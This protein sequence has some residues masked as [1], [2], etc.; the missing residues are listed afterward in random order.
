MMDF[1][2][3][4]S[5]S[6]MTR[7]EGLSRGSEEIFMGSAGREVARAV[8]EYVEGHGLAKQ[9]TLLA[10]K[11]N[12]GGDAYAAGIFLLDAGFHVHAYSLYDEGSSLNCLYRE[13]F[14]KK[15]GQFVE[16]LEGVLVDG[17]LGT[18]FRGEIE[19]KLASFIAEIN[20]SGLPVISID[21]PSG[22]NGTTGEVLGIAVIADETVTLG[23]PKMGLFL[24]DGWNHVGNLRVAD[25]GLPQE[26]I[27]A[28]E[29]L[30]YLPKHLDLPRIVRNRHKYQAG[31]VVGMGGSK[32]MPG[33]VKLAGLAALKA[34][35]GIVRLFHLEEIGPV[36]NELISVDWDAKEWKRGVEKAQAIFVGPG[37]GKSR[38]MRAWLKKY[39][40]TIKQHCVIDAD[41]LLPG[42]S[43][44]KKAVLTPHKGEVLRLLELSEAPGDEELFAK[45]ILFCNRN[46]LV[47]VLKG[48][49]TFVFAPHRGPVIIPYGDP[50]MATAGSGDVL[51][52]VISA[53]LAQGC[54]ALQ[55]SVLGAALH[56]IAGEWA[57]R[58]KTSYSITA[59]DLIEFLPSAFH[60]LLDSDMTQTNG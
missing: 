55:A 39:L 59:S 44:P 42:L 14:K 13:R 19:T 53:L 29:P 22:V 41:A 28:A 46:D 16:R 54:S 8:A 12:N 56:G 10:G 31:Y 3:V 5:V 27:D 17:L 47:L 18:G 40:K 51:T 21:I 38:K 60:S 2:K 26:S 20:E 9:V 36:A 6:E 4:V 1:L 32:E 7:I 43:F 11:G 34:G 23:L 33:S 25:F 35:A 50:G 57:A 48:A 24:R 58:E 52:G 49:P 45:V 15:G 37:I 30:A